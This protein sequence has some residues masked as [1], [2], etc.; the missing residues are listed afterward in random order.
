MFLYNCNSCEA[1]VLPSV[2]TVLFSLHVSF[3][4]THCFLN[5]Y[6]DESKYNNFKALFLKALP[7]HVKDKKNPE[8]KFNSLINLY[9]KKPKRAY[10]I[11]LQYLIAQ[12]NNNSRGNKITA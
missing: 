7:A 2:I 9:E 10:W 3:A 8:W 5:I 6:S 12:I 1:S 4:Y 11:S